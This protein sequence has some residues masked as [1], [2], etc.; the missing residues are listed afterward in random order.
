MSVRPP[1][2]D[3]D[4][5]PIGAPDPQSDAGRLIYLLEWARLR[6]FRLGPTL[7]IG[8][9]IVQVADLR[10]VEGRGGGERDPGPWVTH[11]HTEDR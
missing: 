1:D 8:G 5:N 10:Q 9:L 11:G 4:G 3:E 6:G 7:Q 2:V